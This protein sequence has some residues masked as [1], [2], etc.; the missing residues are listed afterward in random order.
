MLIKRL[1]AAFGYSID[2]LRLISL[3]NEK[4]HFYWFATPEA[5]ALFR[6]ELRAYDELVRL[7]S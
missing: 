2:V 4:R 3:T 6:H 7:A 1:F 5:Y